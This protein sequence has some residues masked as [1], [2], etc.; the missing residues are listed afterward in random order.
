[1]R[2]RQVALAAHDLAATTDALCAVLGIEIGFRD[3]GVAVFGLVNAVMPL[4][5]SFLEVVSPTADDAPARRYLARRGGDCGYM[6][7]VQTAAFDADRARVERLG[8]R[9]V[10]SGTL[11]DIRGMHLHPKDTGG[12]LLSL[13][14]PVPASEWRWAGHDWRAHPGAGRVGPL[15]GA[16]IAC[17]R[18][19]AVAERWGALLDLAPRKDE[20]GPRI[21]LDASFLRFVPAASPA[22]E[23]LVAFTV[24]ARDPAAVLSAARARG[25]ATGPASVT[26]CATRIELEAMDAPG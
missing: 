11:P 19:E 14:E 13:D 25:L 18:P 1:V 4:G 20:R 10:W 16:T 9:V 23:G 5:D 2:L 3:P 15:R 8:A 21:D 17:L 26:V 7:M 12:A 24:A 22:G 6:V